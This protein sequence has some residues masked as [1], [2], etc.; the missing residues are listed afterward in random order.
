MRDSPRSRPACTTS[1]YGTLVTSRFSVF[2][3][4][5]SENSGTPAAPAAWYFPGLG[6]GARGELG[7]GLE[8]GR[9]RHAGGHDGVAD[10]R[11][12]REI[13]L[14]VV[15]QLLL[16]V[17]MRHERCARRVEQHVIVVG[18]GEGVDGDQAV[19]ARPVLD[20]HRLAPLGAEP[21]GEQ[22]RGD[23]GGAAGAERQDPADAALR[24]GLRLSLAL[25]HR[26]RRSSP[27][28]DACRS[29]DAGTLARHS[30]SRRESERS[31]E[32]LASVG[33]GRS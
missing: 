25:R 18:R 28:Q 33:G 13:A 31:V 19:A 8:L 20:H 9:G 11:D 10:P 30:A 32:N 14:Q 26:K 1:R 15:G 3:N 2:R 23:V 7:D 6:L 4:A 12:R 5:P 17:G 27:A 24:P 16:R 29:R 21:L 22:A